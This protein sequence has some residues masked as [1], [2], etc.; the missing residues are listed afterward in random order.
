MTEKKIVCC[1]S[2][3]K[4]LVLSLEMVHE[5]MIADALI[6]TGQSAEEALAG[7]IASLKAQIVLAK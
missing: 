6:Y 4:A 1:E 3:F 5:A 7:I 2:G